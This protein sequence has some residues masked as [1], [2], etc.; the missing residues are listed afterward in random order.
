MQVK[1]SYMSYNQ[2]TCRQL[3]CLGSEENALC[4]ILS[5]QTSCCHCWCTQ[6]DQFVRGLYKGK[7]TG[8]SRCRKWTIGRDVCHWWLLLNQKWPC[9]EL[10]QCWQWLVN[11]PCR[12]DNFANDDWWLMIRRN[13][14]PILKLFRVLLIKLKPKDYDFILPQ[15]KTKITLSPVHGMSVNVLHSLE[16]FIALTSPQRLCSNG[17][18][19]D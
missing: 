9:D 1:P 11:G 5:I 3:V 2:K 16:G 13:V 19:V 4:T 15:L 18:L 6:N 14:Q 7:E 12:V 10:C 8:L 17:W